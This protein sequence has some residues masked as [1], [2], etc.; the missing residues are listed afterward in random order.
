LLIQH[1]YAG[2]ISWIKR[3]SR[4]VRK[5]AKILKS[6]KSIKRLIILFPEKRDTLKLFA[7]PKN[8]AALRTLRDI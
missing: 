2:K 4:K 5:D 8:L 7:S 3:I 6:L 1:S